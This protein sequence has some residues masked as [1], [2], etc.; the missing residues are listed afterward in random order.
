MKLVNQQRKLSAFRRGGRKSVSVTL[1]MLNGKRMTRRARANPGQLI[2]PAGVEGHLQAEAALLERHFP[3]R[4]F[5]L[6][7]LRDGNFNFIE[8]VTVAEQTA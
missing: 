7:E 6:V 5:R 1:V 4:E 2:T 8:I 3:G